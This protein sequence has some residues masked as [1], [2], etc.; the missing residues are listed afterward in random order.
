LTVCAWNQRIRSVLQRT[1]IKRNLLPLYC[2]QPGA[3]PRES[4]PRAGLESARYRQIYR[5]ARM[6]FQR[7]FALDLTHRTLAWAIGVQSWHFLYCNDGIDRPFWSV[8]T[9]LEL[10]LTVSRPP[11]VLTLACGTGCCTRGSPCPCVQPAFQPGLEA[12]LREADPGNAYPS[13]A[14][15]PPESSTLP[16]P[17]AP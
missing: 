12:K 11:L 14:G 3:S 4:T 16:I 2:Q 15:F 13:G 7:L 1:S 5:R 17:L 6:H 10:G 8:E 9:V